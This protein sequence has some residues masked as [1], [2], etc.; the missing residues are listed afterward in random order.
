[1]TAGRGAR[2]GLRSHFT[3]AQAMREK[4]NQRTLPC[5]PPATI[6]GRLLRHQIG[7]R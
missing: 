4:R 6:M 7:A 2:D 3:A 1:M 5:V